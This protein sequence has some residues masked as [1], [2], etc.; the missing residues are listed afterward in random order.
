LEIVLSNEPAIPLL[1]MYP[2]DTSQYHKGTCSTSSLIHNSQELEAHEMSLNK[3]WIKKMWFI[4]TME[5]YLA[6]KKQGHD[7]FCRQMDGT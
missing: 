5:Y 2:K 7:E 1:G 4:C 6:I 3:E